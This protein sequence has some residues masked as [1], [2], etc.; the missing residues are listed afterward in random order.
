MFS[1]CPSE[2]GIVSGAE[3]AWVEALNGYKYPVDLSLFIKRRAFPNWFTENMDGTRS[4]T[5][6]FEDRFRAFA[7]RHVEVWY[8][9]VFWKMFSQ[10]GR[11]DQ[12]TIDVIRRIE[13]TGISAEKLYRQCCAF[14]EQP[15]RRSLQSIVELLWGKGARTIA[16]ACVFPDFIDPV[17]FP[18]VD[19]RI[20]K[21]A[22]A[23]LEKHNAADP[24]GPQLIPPV[25]PRNGATVLTLSDWPF[26]ESWINWCR[27]TGQKLTSFT[28]FDWRA[29]DVEMAIFRAWGN[30]IER[31][32][33]AKDRPV[34]DLPPLGTS[35]KRFS[36]YD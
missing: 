22:T 20:A 16:I 7:E 12:D 17:R 31:R 32:A 3:K 29:R 24:D 27:Y 25:Y 19:T 15:T 13:S 34:I 18:M 2:T 33:V 23:C 8:E 35:Q 10:K 14:I 28:G 1:M 9:G 26:I 5:K 36:V 30:P 6:A 4:A 21:W 11:R